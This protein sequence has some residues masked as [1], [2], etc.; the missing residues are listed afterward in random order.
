M[1]RFPSVFVLASSLALLVSG[2]DSRSGSSSNVPTPA[3]AAPSGKSGL[4]F[5]PGALG[6]CETTAL[7]KV[8]WDVSAREGVKAVNIVTVRPTG[9]EAMF[10]RHVRSVGM[11]RTGRWIRAGRQFVVRD[12][13]GGAELARASIGTLPCSASS[14]APKP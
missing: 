11:K 1:L 4:W 12:A 14:G 2:C 6:S 10:A 9:E 13:R 3:T 8:R 5:D 7:V